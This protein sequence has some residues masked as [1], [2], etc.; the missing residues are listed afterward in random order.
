[1]SLGRGGFCRAGVRRSLCT[2]A[3][4][5]RGGN[6]NEL[7]S[8]PQEGP[9]QQDG[10]SASGCLSCPP[11]PPSKEPGVRQNLFTGLHQAYEW[12]W[13]LSAVL[14]PM[15]T[16]GSS[17]GKTETGTWTLLKKNAPSWP[18]DNYF[19]DLPT[20]S[21]HSLCSSPRIFP[22]AASSACPPGP[23]G[24]SP[25]SHGWLPRPRLPVGHTRNEANTLMAE[26]Q[27]DREEMDR[28]A[29]PWRAQDLQRPGSGP[30][31]PICTRQR[32]TIRGCCTAV[33][34]QG[35]VLTDTTCLGMEITTADQ[36]SGG[37][38]VLCVVRAGHRWHLQG[39][40]SM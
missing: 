24:T 34:G 6:T 28:Q 12:L 11:G 17:E 20:G 13:A 35:G 27:K 29:C 1:M 18:G 40:A 36:L 9:C 16:C 22:A 21:N 10:K 14:V 15:A 30:P 33:M 31:A 38:W 25:S 23:K 26:T 4:C 3:Q 39:Q 8:L 5:S 32:E 2:R 7:M 37:T 19:P